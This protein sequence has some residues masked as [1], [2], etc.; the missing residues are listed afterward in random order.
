MNIEETVQRQREFFNSD[1]TKDVSFRIQQ[2]KNLQQWI[3]NNDDKIAAAL[4]SDLN[5]APFEAYATETGLTLEEIKFQLKHV[6]KWSKPKRVK[7]PITQ[8]KSKSKIYSEPYGVTLIM[9]PWNYPFQ[10]AV[11]PLVCAI[12]AGNTAVVK[13]SAY[14]PATSELLKQMADELFDPSYVA[15]ITGGREQNADLLKRKFDFIFFTGSVNVGKTVMQSASANLTPVCLELGGKSPCIVDKSAK[16]PVAAK[17]IVWGK[18][19]NAGQTCVAPDY[20]LV[21]KDVKDALV[22]EMEKVVKEFY[23]DNAL[24]NDDFPK[25]INKK[26]FDRVK[27]LIDGKVLFGGNYDENTLKIQPTLIEADWQS[28]AMGEEIF[29]PVFPLITYENIDEIISLL[30]EKPHPLALYVFTEDKSISDKVIRSLQY[31]GGCVNDT[32]IHLATSHMPFGGAGDSGMGGYHGKFGF[33]TFSHRKSVVDK[34]TAL[35][36]KLRYPPYK[37]QLNLLKKIQK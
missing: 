18:F 30:K 26:H 17:R 28:K 35:D 33:D 11:V 4:K 15:V 27:G 3:R 34:S 10:L 5:K 25:I 23:G 22:A 14:S 21:H 8:F 37:N 1:K 9:S 7:T 32:I 24:T 6:K 36:I 31:G 29:G 13:P 2:L 19:L 12:A 16:I 20:L